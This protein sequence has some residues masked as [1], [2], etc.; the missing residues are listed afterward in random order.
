MTV[1]ILLCISRETQD[2]A[3]I[4]GLR[5]CDTKQK[6]QYHYVGNEK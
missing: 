5:H 3:Y 6:T 4:Q 1:R 2:F